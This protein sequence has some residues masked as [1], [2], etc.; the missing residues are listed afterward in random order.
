[1]NSLESLLKKAAEVLQQPNS[2][3]NYDELAAFVGTF[4]K[5]ADAF[6]ETAHRHG[7]PLYVFEERA[8]LERAAQFAAA[9][10]ETLGDIRIFYAVKSN[11]HPV[12]VSSLVR[13]GLGLDVSSG[14]EL[15]LALRCSCPD[16]IFSGPGKTDKELQLAVRHSNHVTVLIDSFG[17]LDRL[18][19]AAAELQTQINAGVR[20]TTDERGLWRKFGIPLARLDGFMQKAIGCSHVLLG[21]LQFHTSW[22]L[23]PGQQVDFIARLGQSLQNLTQNRRELIKFIDIG[24]GYWPP[25]GEWLQWAGTSKG[26][27][28]QALLNTSFPSTEH[29]KLSSSSI[30][31]FATKIGAAVQRHVAP[32]VDC[33]FYAEPGRWLCNDALHILLTVVDK[34]SEDLVITDGGTNIIGWE[35][36]ETDYFPVINLSRP[37]KS[38]H[39]CFILGSLCTPH[40]VWGY[41]YF[42]KGIEAGDLLLIPN[43]G[44][45]TYS[46]RQEFIKPLPE[47]VALYSAG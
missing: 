40:D 24:G 34:K 28:H 27:L 14:L 32:Y 23:D 16:I 7:S 3:L 33:L 36:F 10:K 8:L 11:N 22:N 46:L 31:T 13:S 38:E 26:R 19:K 4:L 35:R 45:Y 17:E 29:Y 2:V 39:K 47:V 21:G 18:E 43:Q 25:Q 42:G 1:M 41:G 37:S 30:T 9:F 44:A 12:L 6:V 20:L 15:E 5:R